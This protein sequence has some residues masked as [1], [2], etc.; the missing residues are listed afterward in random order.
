MLW[1]Q[2][3]YG[4]RAREA[5]DDPNNPF[6]KEERVNGDL[7]LSMKSFETEDNS[8]KRDSRAEEGKSNSEIASRVGRN[9][10]SMKKELE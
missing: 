3:D 7:S 4:Q 9:Y 10:T 1:G 5:E 8:S 2:I 6:K